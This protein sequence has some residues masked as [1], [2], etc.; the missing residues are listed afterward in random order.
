LLLWLAIFFAFHSILLDKQERFSIEWTPALAAFAG[1]G[2][3]RIEARLPSKTKILAWALVGLWLTATLYPAVTYNITA[4]N[5]Q[6]QQYG[7]VDEFM[8]VSNWIV[9]N[10]SS[11]TRGATD[12]PTALAY[13]TD[14]SYF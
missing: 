7:S 14:R 8:S 13:Q 11:T 3:S 12:I 5:S 4:A 6:V 1:L 9:A 2:F 10:T